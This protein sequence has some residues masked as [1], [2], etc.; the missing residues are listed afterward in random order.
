ML[1]TASRSPKAYIW[2]S[3]SVW[4]PPH[5]YEKNSMWQ[6]NTVN[7]FL[8]PWTPTRYERYIFS[9]YFSQFLQ[10]NKTSPS[11]TAPQ[12]RKC[13]CDVTSDS[14]N[15]PNNRWPELKQQPTKC[16]SYIVRN[17]YNF[18]AVIYVN[19][20]SLIKIKRVW[21]SWQS[22]SLEVHFFSVLAF[23]CSQG[24]EDKFFMAHWPDLIWWKRT[25]YV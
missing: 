1:I 16:S 7:Y 15:H 10:W 23:T 14:N 21:K 11:D 22:L 4:S 17:K 13:S 3:A 20:N 5:K 24:H 6:R 25:L 18:T 8:Q 19:F 2:M 9:L 12:H